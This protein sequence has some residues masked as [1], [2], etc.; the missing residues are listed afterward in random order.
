MRIILSIV[1]V[2][3]KSPMILI[4]GLWTSRYRSSTFF[5]ATLHKLAWAFPKR[6]M[7]FW[8][9]LSKF[10]FIFF[11]R[12]VNKLYGREKIISVTK[13][14][15]HTNYSFLVLMFCLVICLTYWA[16]NGILVTNIT[17]FC[18]KKPPSLFFK[19][20]SFYFFFFEFATI[21]PTLKKFSSLPIP[22]S[23]ANLNE[24]DSY[25]RLLLV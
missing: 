9:V 14:L 16:D 13:F 20:R 12:F 21:M 15:L 8:R 23:E 7:R 10:S 18:R 1:H 25:Q 6:F 19:R 24:T 5:I 4:H 2:K 3:I 17:Y 11:F 22:L